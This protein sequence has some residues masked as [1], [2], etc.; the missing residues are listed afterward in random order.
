M[1]VK[2]VT[3][4]SSN[5]PPFKQVIEDLEDLEEKVIEAAKIEEAKIEEEVE[6]EEIE[7]GFE[8]AVSMT[9]IKNTS[10]LIAGV[11]FLRLL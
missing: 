5:I 2:S 7:E 9:I 8:N 6:E 3:K 4:R 1:N 11:L 10:C